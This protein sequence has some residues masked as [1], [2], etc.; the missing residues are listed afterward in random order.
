[1]AN[2]IQIK[3]GLEAD[4]SSVTPA[5]GELLYTTDEK[6]V[7]V[8]DG[9]T[10]GGNAVAPA[11]SG[12]VALT[13]AASEFYAS[14]GAVGSAALTLKIQGSVALSDTLEVV[15]F[16]NTIGSS[17]YA[18]AYDSDTD[19][20]GSMITLC[21]DCSGSV[22]F[23]PI[24]VSAT[25]ILVGYTVTSTYDAN[26]FT[27]SVSGTT[28]TKNSVTTSSAW[29]WLQD[30]EQF[31]SYYVFMGANTSQTAAI[32]SCV[33]VSSNAVTVE[34]T[35][36]NMASQAAGNLTS[37]GWNVVNY[38]DTLGVI[39]FPASTG[40]MQGAGF[41]VS[42]GT[43]TKIGSHTNLATMDTLWGIQKT[44]NGIFVWGSDSNLPELSFI[45]V[46]SSAFSVSNDTGFGG[47]YLS[48]YNTGFLAYGDW[49]ICC[50]Q[51]S[52]SGFIQIHVS[53]FR[54]NAGTLQTLTE[55]YNPNSN[56]AYGPYGVIFIP[57]A[58]DTLAVIG[59]GGAFTAT[60]NTSTASL[61]IEQRPD[62]RASV[63]NTYT[64]SFNSPTTYNYMSRY[65]AKSLNWKKGFIPPE[66]TDSSYQNFTSTSGKI[67][68]GYAN[69]N[70]NASVVDTTNLTLQAAPWSGNTAPAPSGI[71]TKYAWICEY[72][73]MTQSGGSGLYD[74][75]N[76]RRVEL[77]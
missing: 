77:A 31:G 46:S 41:E 24:K 73:T 37:D 25:E 27:I 55:V 13:T 48:S 45:K 16:Q 39:I 20:F 18:Q 38:T 53:L 30:V 22:Q 49:L 58:A 33:S 59:G 74:L 57:T 64:D 5:A 52:G 15:F 9:T 75:T 17:F 28:L 10:A 43:L 40:Q 6:K 63:I 54:D 68:A 66:L 23:H 70:L 56:Y 69:S 8:G 36:L 71:A 35:S 21:T 51:S 4:R 14:K 2:T 26:Y 50:S 12:G 44:T 42:A 32:I 29:G 1:M 62:L 47:G 34:T 3:R 11:A 72:G 61:D 60:I 7:Y 19:T 67:Y 65:F 76:Y